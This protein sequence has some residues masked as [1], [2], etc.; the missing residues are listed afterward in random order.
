MPNW[1]CLLSL[2]LC[3]IRIFGIIEYE[4]DLTDEIN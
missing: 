4:A 3:Q 1:M 2:G